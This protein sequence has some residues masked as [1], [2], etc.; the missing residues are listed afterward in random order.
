MLVCPTRVFHTVFAVL[1]SQEPV[2]LVNAILNGVPTAT[3]KRDV[4]VFVNVYEALPT[5]STESSDIVD[6]PTA[7]PVN[8]IPETEREAPDINV[9]VP[10]PK[11]PP[12]S[13]RFPEPPIEIP[14]VEEIELPAVI[15]RIP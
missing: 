1:V 15:P 2:L 6:P 5:C 3:S 7:N 10:L 8:E 9:Y 11:T 14:A 4:G 12:T 13:I